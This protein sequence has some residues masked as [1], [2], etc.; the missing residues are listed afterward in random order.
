VYQDLLSGRIDLFFDNTTTAAPYIEA[1]QVKPLAV[2]SRERVAALPR[3]PTVSETGLLDLEME[4]WFGLFA[5]ARAPRPV[6]AR[7]RAEIERAVDQPEVRKRLEQGSGRSLRM[8][9]AQTEAFVRAEVP[10]WIALV[11]KA[12]ITPE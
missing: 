5:P 2:S 4:T 6:V 12:G 7:L 1:G 3:V 9:A 10:R 8:G 11:R